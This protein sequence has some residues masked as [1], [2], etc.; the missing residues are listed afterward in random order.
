MK[1]LRKI[2]VCICLLAMTATVWA[3]GSKEDNTATTGQKPDMVNVSA[4]NGPSSIGMAYMFE[5]APKLDGVPSTFSISASPDILLPKLIKGEV[6][7]G[8]LP[9][10]AAAKVYNA[11]NEAIILGGIVG[12]GMMSILSRN[13]SITTLEDL[14]GKK[15]TVAGQGSTPEYI[16]RYL[17]E[18][19]G[20]S[21]GTG[22]DSIELDFSLPTA[23][24][25][26]ALIS[27]KIAYAL[28]PEPFSTIILLQ[29]PAKTIQIILDVQKL[30]EKAS[31]SDKNYP[32]TAVVVRKEFA[33]K[34]PQTLRLFLEAYEQSIVWVNAN[35]QKA[36]TL[37]E[38]HALGLKAAIV[39]KAIPNSAIIWQSA[40][41]A[42]ASVEMLLSLFLD[43][44]PTSIGGKL[45]SEGF[46]FK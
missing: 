16:I 25:A 34:Y 32:V 10:N 15:L 11:N 36:G 46:Y 23:E 8:V 28:V 27:N 44:A 3:G 42:Q 5:N 30:Y 41:D 2:S 29:D 13:T 31:G 12:Q 19:N 18:E 26:P 20:I 43:F 17:C 7:I 1:I 9:I 4:L 24:I 14:K 6:D 35:P 33:E 40:L 22:A 45:P 21:I 38:K 37:V 39:A